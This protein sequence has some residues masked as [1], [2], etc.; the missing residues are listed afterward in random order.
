M[1]MIH[2]SV[3]WYVPNRSYREKIVD[4][5]FGR[6]RARYVTIRKLVVADS[7]NR[8]SLVARSV[9]SD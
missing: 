9:T 1:S 6:H 8:V 4:R 7:Q 5:K 2:P 3:G